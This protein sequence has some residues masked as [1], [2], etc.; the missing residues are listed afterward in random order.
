MRI[1]VS[2][3][4][5]H[6]ASAS[7]SS[8]LTAAD[9]PPTAAPADYEIGIRRPG[10]TFGDLQR[11]VFCGD[12]APRCVAVDGEPVALE[13]LIVDDLGPGSIVSFTDEAVVATGG[14]AAPSRVLRVVG[15]LAAGASI[16]LAVGDQV[17]GR[18]A[19]CAIVLASPTVSRRHARLTIS[20]H[21]TATLTDLGSTN[22]T[23]VG[24]EPARGS[25]A[26]GLDEPAQVGATR[27]LV[28][29]ATQVTRA[30]ARRHSHNRPPRV[31][32]PDPTPGV[33]VPVAPRPIAGRTPFSWAMVLAPLAIAVVMALLFNPIFAV[34]A[35]LSPVMVVGSWVEQRHRRA[36]EQRRSSRALGSSMK[37]FALDLRAAADLHTRWLAD[38]APDLAT[39]VDRLDRR[40]PRLWER[41]PDHDDFGALRVGCATRAW[42]PPLDLAAD[43]LTPEAAS[44]I[45][46]HAV[47]RDAPVTV[48]VGPGLV[49]GIAGP[50]RAARAVARSLVIQAVVHHGP[51][52]LWIALATTDRRAE[53]WAFTSWLPHHHASPDPTQTRR[54]TTEG[55]LRGLATLLSADDLADTSATTPFGLVVIDAADARQEATRAADP[56]TDPRSSNALDDLARSVVPRHS[57]IVLAA[58]PHLLPASCTA[59]IECLDEDG[60]G[61]V[62]DPRRGEQV[63]D[64]L[65]DGLAS[66]T[67]LDIARRLSGITDPEAR[68]GSDPL[69][70]DADLGALLLRADEPEVPRTDAGETIASIGGAVPRDDAAQVLRRW[71]RHRSNPGLPAVVGV[72]A[73]GAHAIDLVT[74]GPHALIGGTTGAG[75]SELLQTWVMA[76]AATHAPDRLT[77]VLIDYKGGSAFDRCARLPH[78]VGLVTDL[79]EQLGSRALRSLDAEIRRR[80]QVLRDAGV[81]DIH[82][83]RGLPSGPDLPRLVVII[84]EF[85]TLAADLPGFLDAL[86]SVAQ[87]GRSLGL[88]LV[89]ATQRPHG[90]INDNIRTN[91]N[92]RIALRMLDAGDS[93]DVL[94]TRDAAAIDRRL[95]GRALSTVGGE[96]PVAWHAARV[97]SIDGGD[98]PP[99]L[100]GAPIVVTAL[101]AFGQPLDADRPETRTT[102]RRCGTGR[103]R[104]VGLVVD[105][106]A[107]SGLRPPRRPWLPP[108]PDVLGPDA[109]AGPTGA[110][111]TAPSADAPVGR[112]APLPLGLTDE[113]DQQRQRVWHWDPGAGP[114]TVYGMPGSGKT[115][116]VLA[117][118]DALARTTG[119][120]DC[121]LYV[122]GSTS[123]ELLATGELPQVGAVITI[124]ERSRI[125]R[126]LRW[127]EEQRRARA[128]HLDGRPAIVVVVDGVAGMLHALDDL[129]G[130]RLLATFLR[131]ASEGPRLGL[132]L[133]LTGDRPQAIPAAA[134]GATDARIVLHLPDPYDYSLLGIRPPSG[135]VPPGRGVLGDGTPI[136][137]CCVR[138]P[139]AASA[140]GGAA[141]G[142]PSRSP[143]RIDD[144]PSSIA[145]VSLPP[146]T[147]TPDHWTLPLGLDGMTLVPVALCLSTGDHVLVAGPPGSGRTTTLLMLGCAFEYAALGRVLVLAPRPNALTEAFPHHATTVTA[148]FEQ[149][150]RTRA[151]AHPGAPA[152]ILVDDCDQVDDDRL[153][154]LLSAERPAL[155]VVAAGRSD[156]LRRSY[157]HWTRPL[158][159]ARFGLALDPTAAH[160][161]DLWNVRL[162]TAGPAVVPGRAVL[163][164]DGHAAVVQVAHP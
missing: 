51:A 26:L 147:M 27:L 28:A 106:F 158:R 18:D 13:Q 102:A 141:A 134:A 131:L 156:R 23:R 143:I 90:A 160:D 101:D 163:V 103:D 58:A 63:A 65:L 47:L 123:P 94:G 148:L 99:D 97:D 92:L 9:A 109:L 124:D 108:L 74:D 155:H 68:T 129:D 93:V 82:A 117:V 157:T 113:P 161:G 122:V 140:A 152:L 67:A 137:L 149:L 37:R 6:S 32:R 21:G 77:F 56:G 48:T 55:E 34:F 125:D 7:P 49:V 111:A 145:L 64:V 44:L 35:A 14:P 126:L 41:R 100:D 31:H 60:S 19:T 138:E 75:K 116:A 89:L 127:L 73:G 96:A 53:H 85:A 76:L 151:D 154:R 79:D 142:P 29:H 83:L 62:T 4:A 121:H 24:G 45:A 132:H 118:I 107:Q 11:A 2:P 95:P 115:G 135:P 50:S 112:L 80:E 25:T 8:S 15:G 70:A 139:G 69:P 104:L 146:A 52:D 54:C 57:A 159:D 136:Q 87:R 81:A 17:I 61:R 78:V 128:Q 1:I 42:V 119:V 12:R 150:A 5:A 164:Q 162:P 3:P 130:R 120:D 40:D 20:A 39:L 30:P 46:V 71:S 91:T 36:R 114:L 10:A 33:H 110:G 105:A 88:H 22:A 43:R 98:A 86:V 144:L 66:T 16:P 38:R 59:V 133:V 72:D 84:D 153:L